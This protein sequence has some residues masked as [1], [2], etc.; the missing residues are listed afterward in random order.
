[1]DGFFGGFFVILD[2]LAER[3][4]MLKGITRVYAESERCELRTVLCMVI[5]KTEKM[6]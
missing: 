3:W 6:I 4:S 1:M 5:K 2:C